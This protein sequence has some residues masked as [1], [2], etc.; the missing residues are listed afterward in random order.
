MKKGSR[1]YI[2]LF[3]LL[4]LYVVLYFFVL[5]PKEKE[6]GDLKNYFNVI[7]GNDANF[8]LQDK[9][10]KLVYKSEWASS[11]WKKF[12]IYEDN[13]YLGDY[14]LLYTGVWNLKNSNKSNTSLTFNEKVAIRGDLDYQ[15]KKFQ[16]IE[17]TEKDSFV[18]QVL[19]EHSINE[20]SSL[21]VFQTIPIDLDKDGELE[22]IYIISNS[23]IDTESPDQIFNFIFSVD[24]GTISMIY[25]EVFSST[26][27]SD[28]CKPFI[29]N[30]FEI[31]NATYFLVNCAKYSDLGKDVTLYRYNSN[32]FT[33]IISN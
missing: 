16:Q 6:N 7:V 5:S 3:L 4:V 8:L 17:N 11:N 22:K 24:D 25:Q 10:W 18:R 14:Y 31:G 32:K 21:T 19:R 20:D 15:I 27:L 30:I 29:S 2:I 26:S 33:K 9:T 1:K 12:Q 13:D 23:F 28:T